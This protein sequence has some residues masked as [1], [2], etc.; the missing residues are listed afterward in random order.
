[1]AQQAESFAQMKEDLKEDI[2]ELVKIKQPAL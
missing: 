1:M 2:D